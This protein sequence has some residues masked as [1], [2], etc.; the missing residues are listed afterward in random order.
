MKDF[1]YD[2]GKSMYGGWYASLRVNNELVG[3]HTKTL[4]ELCELVKEYGL[5][6]T[7][8]TFRYDN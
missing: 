3:L 2:Y 1:I 5:E 8:T 6:I 7:E 4:E